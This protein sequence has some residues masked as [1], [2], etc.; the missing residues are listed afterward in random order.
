MLDYRTRM[1]NRLR[2]ILPSQLGVRYIDFEE[3]RAIIISLGTVKYIQFTNRR[4]DHHP[5]YC[6]SFNGSM[7]QSLSRPLVNS[8]FQDTKNLKFL[9]RIFVTFDCY[10]VMR[11]I[12]FASFLEGCENIASSVVT[13]LDFFLFPIVVLAASCMTFKFRKPLTNFLTLEQR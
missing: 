8:L 2:S 6:S 4:P 13:F 7:N 3:R 11:K 1:V 12:L 9:I 5:H 10:R